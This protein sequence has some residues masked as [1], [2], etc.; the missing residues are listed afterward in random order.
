MLRSVIKIKKNLVLAL[1]LASLFLATSANST[2]K[3]NNIFLVC[4]RHKEVRW[5]RIF[6][7]TDGKCK[8]VY[9]KEGFSQ[10]VS[11]ATYFSSCEAV[12]NNVKKNIEDGGFKC[13]EQKLGMVVEVD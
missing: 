13:R 1:C 7:G 3:S 8:S 10:I 12:L 6:T 2:E 5:L 4:E 9:S 11:S